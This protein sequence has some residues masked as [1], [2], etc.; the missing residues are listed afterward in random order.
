[1]ATA[2][3][4]YPLASLLSVEPWDDPNNRE[5]WVYDIRFERPLNYQNPQGEQIQLSFKLV[6]G[7]RGG[8]NGK[9]SPNITASNLQTK[10]AEDVHVWNRDTGNRVAGCGERRPLL[11]FLC[12][13]PGAGNNPSRIPLLNQRFLEDGYWILY[14]DYRGTGDSSPVAHRTSLEWVERNFKY[15]RQTDIVRDLESFRQWLLGRD[16]KWTLFGQSFGGWIIMSYLSFQ[17]QGLKK[18]YLT[19]G[20]PPIGVPIADHFK[21]TYGRIKILNKRFYDSN[22][23]NKTLVKGIAKDLIELARRGES[24]KLD[25]PGEGY[26]G[27]MTPKRFLSLGRTM[28]GVE[29]YHD[30]MHR[31]CEALKTQLTEMLEGTRDALELKLVA[32]LTWLDG[33]RFWR[34]APF[35][36]L[37]ESIFVSA[38]NEASDWMAYRIAQTMPEFSWVAAADEN[39][40]DGIEP[41]GFIYFS[42][43][44]IYPAWYKAYDGLERFLDN[45]SNGFRGIAQ[46]IQDYP[47]H[48]PLYDVAQLHRNPVPVRAIIFE[49]DFCI[50]CKLSVK[51]AAQVNNID[52]IIHPTLEHSTI[53]YQADKLLDM[54]DKPDRIVV[55]MA[56]GEEEQI[57]WTQVRLINS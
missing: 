39:I 52:Y 50:S 2:E 31:F 41:D 15:L 12:G 20:I 55:Q 28:L 8:A 48:E 9:P 36:L 11:V 22:R 13:G 25:I 10:L 56:D 17:P 1:M 24:P 30:E 43:E 19:A 47:W 7:P 27:I 53:N 21:D 46:D 32:K 18:C 14:P 40:L 37:Y 51:A 38:K 54:I 57:P 45:G 3:V 23:E 42:G 49:K 35:A 34:R 33:F 29:S 26:T 44:M 4:L 16:T 5:V 6:C